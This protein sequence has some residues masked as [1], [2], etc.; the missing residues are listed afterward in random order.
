[1]L[2]ALSRIHAPA[3]LADP[4]VKVTSIEVGAPVA[5]V[6]PLPTGFRTAIGARS[7]FSKDSSELYQAV[8]ESIRLYREQLK[9]EYDQLSVHI[10]R[11]RTLWL[12][13]V[14]TGFLIL[15]LGI[16]TVIAG[17]ATE[18]IIAAASTPI[19]YFRVRILQQREDHYRQLRE[20]KHRHLEYGNGWLMAIQTIAGIDDSP[21][22]RLHAPRRTRSTISP[23]VAASASCQ[24]FAEGTSRYEIEPAFFHP[25][26]KSQV[27]GWYTT[28][29]S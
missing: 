12:A 5:A 26:R 2:A 28:S 4:V 11:T 19:I 25:S 1:V 6:R 8:Q 3:T 10:G 21:R 16:G 22:L 17:R 20:Q 14:A 27:F 15:L 18:G 7:M 23:V 9:R 13:C 24:R 29:G